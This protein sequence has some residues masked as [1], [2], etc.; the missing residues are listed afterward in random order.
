LLVVVLMGVMGC[1]VAAPPPGLADPFRERFTAPVLS[2]QDGD[3]LTVLRQGHQVRVR[4][5][6]VDA[7][8]LGQPFGRAAKRFTAARVF[9]QQVELLVYDT[10][11]DGRLVCEVLLAAGARLS[12]A[13]VAN[14][15]AW[16]YARLAPAD[17]K[18]QQLEAAARLAHRGLWSDPEPVP[19]WL[20]RTP[21]QAH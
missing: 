21:A 13:L 4:L 18:L 3:S 6:G 11:H 14:G 17:R 9:G 7:P 2:V 5:Y 1:S 10:D 16:W 15:L 8:E 19:P 12:A 20:W